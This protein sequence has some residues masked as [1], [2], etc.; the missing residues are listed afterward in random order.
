MRA[1]FTVSYN[2]LTVGA[3]EVFQLVG[4]A[5]GPEIGQATIANLVAL[6]VPVLRAAL[7]ERVCRTIG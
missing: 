6:P 7:R 3:A 1:A 5:P 4:L 2:A